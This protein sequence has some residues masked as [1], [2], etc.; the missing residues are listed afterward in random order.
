ML[1]DELFL[2]EM[3][4][5]VGLGQSKTSQVCRLLKQHTAT[6]TDDVVLP[7]QDCAKLHNYTQ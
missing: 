6:V 1:I 3:A 2:W 7:E 4:V 5:H